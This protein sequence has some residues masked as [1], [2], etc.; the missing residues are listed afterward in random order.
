MSN[1]RQPNIPHVANGF[2]DLTRAPM[3]DGIIAVGA[4]LF[5]CYYGFGNP[6]VGRDAAATA[7][8]QQWHQSWSKLLKISGVCLLVFG[9]L[10][11]VV[12]LM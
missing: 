10:D 6:P 8:W 7:K 5:A 4:G 1:A 9:I 2:N 11:V 12:A 3:I